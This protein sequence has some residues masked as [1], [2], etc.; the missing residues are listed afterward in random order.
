MLYGVGSI[1]LVREPVANPDF[2][3]PVC[4]SNFTLEKQISRKV[5][6]TLI[7]NS[8][9]TVGIIND[10]EAYYLTL[11][12]ELNNIHSVGFADDRIIETTGATQIQTSYNLF[13]PA[14]GLAIIPSEFI[15]LETQGIYNLSKD[16]YLLQID[17][18]DF[19]ATSNEIQFNAQYEG[20]YVQVG[21]FITNSTGKQIGDDTVGSL[22]FTGVTHGIFNEYGR[23]EL[24]IQ[25]TDL[26]P[27]GQWTIGINGSSSSK[28]ISKY[29]VIQQNPVAFVAQPSI[30]FY[31]VPFGVPAP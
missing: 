30:T 29:V 26:R 12:T 15:L 8:I 28:I 22:T 19:T 1:S 4:F 21:L 16:I 2:L 14:G 9:K 3:N 6:Q 17:D 25:V 24:I 10:E 13:V 11:E 23:E 18:Y 31:R 5:H 20:D 7:D 27:I